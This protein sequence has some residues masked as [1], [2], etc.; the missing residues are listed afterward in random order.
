MFTRLVLV[1]SII[2]LGSV[3]GTVDAGVKIEISRVKE[4]R[5]KTETASNSDNTGPQ[6]LAA[7]NPNEI[8]TTV[9][10]TFAIETTTTMI[11]KPMIETNYKLLSNSTDTTSVDMTTIPPPSV[12]EP[13]KTAQPNTTIIAAQ[14][15]MTQF[16]SQY[17][18]EFARRE[19]RRKL[20]PP[21]YYCPC[22]LKVKQSFYYFVNCIHLWSIKL[23]S[24]KCPIN[25]LS[26]Q[27]L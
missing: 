8:G 1:L 10:T 2:Y 9:P 19:M 5:P 26:D 6:E 12:T 23:N 16:Q 4:P 22:D 24:T 7:T 18:T 27:F 21:D 14:K 13:T 20:I 3:I 17:L 15:N 25:R 11:T